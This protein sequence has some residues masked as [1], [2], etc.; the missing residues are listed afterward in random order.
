MLAKIRNYIFTGL[1]VTLPLVISI[2]VLGWI[3]IK[4][5][6]VVL[7]LLP[8]AL[9]SKP[10]WTM[11]VRLVIPVALL[12]VL[13]L[14]GIIAKIV[15]VR[16][17]FGLGERLLIK[18]PLFNKVYIAVKQISQAFL[19]K[20]KTIFKRV[21]LVEYP[22]KGLYS[23]GFVTTRT[24]GEVQAKTKGEMLNVFV[25]T[26]PNPTSGVLIFARPSEVIELDMSVE[27]GLKLVVSGGAV[28]PP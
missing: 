4:L 13:A 11:A 6:N 26:T 27:D 2:T 23:I 15:F 18:I 17:L 5:T 20:D 10:G 7:R 16:K 3:F 12:V 9:S 19:D 21:V 8:P 25:P 28:T 1:V 14:V 22:R 24:R